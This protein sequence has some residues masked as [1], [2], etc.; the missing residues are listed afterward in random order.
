M[1]HFDNCPTVYWLI[2]YI[3]AGI[4]IFS[5]VNK[6][7]SFQLFAMLSAILLVYMRL[8]V[9]MFNR[10]LNA[11]ESQMLSHAITLLQ[12]P[13]YWRSVDGTTIGPLD[14][15]L[16][17]IPKFFGFQI[18]YTS[19]RIMGLTCTIGSML[20]LLS[21]LKNW[22]GDLTAR[23]ALLTPLLFLAFTQE[24]DFV[25]YSSEQLPVLLLSIITWLLSRY[26]TDVK[27]ISANS[28]W[29]GFVAGLTP[30]AKLQAVPQALVLVLGAMWY[31][32]Q[33]YTHNKSFRPVLM[34]LLGGIT[35]PGLALVWIIAHNVFTDLIDF[36]LLGNI[37]YA[38]GNDKLSIPEQFIGIIRL[39]P[40]FT[41]FFMLLC[42]PAALGLWFLFQ[43]SSRRALPVS[44][45]IIL[46]ICSGVY[47][48]T[49]SGSAFVH[50]LNFYIL[51][52][53]LLAACGM[54]K[55]NK[56]A[57]VLPI[58]FLS[59]AGLSDFLS[60]KNQHTLNSF[61]SDN[62][63][64]LAQSEVVRE[65]K[66]YSKKGDYMVVWGWQCTYYVEA[67]L[68][69]GTAENHS[70]RSIFQHR[71]TDQ[72]RKRYIADIQRTKPAIFIDA[73]GKNSLWAQN[74]ATQGFENYPALE[75]YISLNYD[76]KG[77][78]DDTRLYV[79]KDRILLRQ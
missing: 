56:F 76:F 67:Q 24:T 50:Y 65:L 23:I 35:F 10:E 21:S 37:I 64:S 71:M 74:R 36:Y 34:L 45:I 55:L 27:K 43:K 14:N 52:W 70:E 29:L 31:C 5:A 25:H 15:Y 7:V 72:Y 19:G 11:D 1:I 69:Q 78:F 73:V 57:I 6:K 30:F 62:A 75:K 8:P 32:Y 77:T 40:D 33:H 41:V 79:R 54:K 46:L 28:Y 16:L 38:S 9:V 63:T 58:L 49:K 22:F 18:D 53:S 3:S 4:V 47:A 17:V 68:A 39:S 12:D 20:F 44:V 61:V 66:K 42:F 48:V 2:G 59:W 51:P 60:Y 13:V 26:E